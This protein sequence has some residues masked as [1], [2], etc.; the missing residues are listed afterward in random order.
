LE[1][2]DHWVTTRLFLVSLVLA[3]ETGSQQANLA[4]LPVFAV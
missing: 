3:R 4:L 1:T 2:Q